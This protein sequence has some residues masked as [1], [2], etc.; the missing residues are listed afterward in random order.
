MLNRLGNGLFPASLFRA[1]RFLRLAIAW[2]LSGNLWL[3]IA[4]L[5][6]RARQE[7]IEAFLNKLYIDR[8]INLDDLHDRCCIGGFVQ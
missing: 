7:F 2:L 8:W 3:L 1:V 5:N 6:R 4:F